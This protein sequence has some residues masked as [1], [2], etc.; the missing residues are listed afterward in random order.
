MQYKSLKIGE[1]YKTKLSNAWQLVTLTSLRT[2]LN[3]GKFDRD[4][5][6]LVRTG[7]GNIIYRRPGELR[8]P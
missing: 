7:A 3:E 5:Q 8:N 1:Q 4:K 6:V 2:E